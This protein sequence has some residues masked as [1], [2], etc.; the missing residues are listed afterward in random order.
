MK[1]LK[2]TYSGVISSK[3]DKS[4]PESISEGISAKNSSSSS[5]NSSPLRFKISLIRPR[6]TSGSDIKVRTPRPQEL[7][8][9]LPLANSEVTISKSPNSR[10]LP[11]SSE[12]QNTA[13]AIAPIPSTSVGKYENFDT[14]AIVK[15]VLSTR[16]TFLIPLSDL[17]I[18]LR[19]LSKLFV[20]REI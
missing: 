3:S 5:F 15:P 4:N 10:F 2:K 14:L 12:A 9:I 18:L 13:L 8:N 6:F 20:S 16:I 17:I 11:C 7:A 1:K 19:I